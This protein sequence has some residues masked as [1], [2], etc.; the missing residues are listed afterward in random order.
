MMLLTKDGGFMGHQS[1]MRI[2]LLAL[3][4]VGMFSLTLR[5]VD[6]TNSYFE[7]PIAMRLIMAVGIVVIVAATKNPHNNS[8][9]R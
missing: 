9:T 6:C 7:I 1:I 8:C 5:Q 4:L 2:I 3:W